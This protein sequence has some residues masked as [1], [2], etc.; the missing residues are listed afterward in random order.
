MLGMIII[1]R[2]FI[3]MG[4]LLSQLQ[5]SQS[6]ALAALAPGSIAPSRRPIA[7]LCAKCNDCPVIAIDETAPEAKRVVITDDFG[8][9]I[10]MSEDQFQVLIDL[11][12]SGA[13]AV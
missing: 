3:P 6:E 4:S 9:E 8:Q 2:E 5:A 12:K 11:A 1:R 13:I 10:Q 7:V